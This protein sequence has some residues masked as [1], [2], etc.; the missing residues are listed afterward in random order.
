MIRFRAFVFPSEKQQHRRDDAGQSDTERREM[1][2]QRERA[3]CGQPEL[4]GE[5]F[6][7]AGN[8]SL[9]DDSSAAGHGLRNA[10][11]GDAENREAVFRCANGRDARMKF[12]L[13]PAPV[14]H[15]HRRDDEQLRALPH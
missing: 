13:V 3:T 10:G 9:R 4:R 5:D 2:V 15:V 7:V 12:M 6:A 11:T 14:F 8:G 1:T